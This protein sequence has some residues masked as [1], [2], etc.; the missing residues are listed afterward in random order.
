MADG[1]YH[2]YMSVKQV[3]EYLQLNEK[4]VYELVKDEQ[5]PAT[6]VTGKWLFPRGLIDRWL[7]DSAH[8]GLLADRLNIAGSDDPLLYRLVLAHMNDIDSHALVNYT[9][10]GTRMGL[11]LLQ[12]RRID[13]CCLH[14]GPSEESALRHPALLEQH[15]QHQQWVLLHLFKREQGMIVRPDVLKQVDA[16]QDL[17]AY[18]WRWVKRQ[19]GAGSQRFL[20]EILGQQGKN[21]D[22]LNLTEQAH[23]EREAAT[24]VAMGLADVSPGPRA[25]A[26]EAGLAFVS[27]GWEAFDMALPKNIWFRHLL[28][29]LLKRLQSVQAQEMAEAYGGYDLSETG[30]LVWGED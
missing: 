14:W 6:K 10:T 17:F 3:A 7:M 9:P 2:A 28:Q 24:L 1:D 26:T 23:S 12:A 25:A 22:D 20:M 19:A 5:I 27:F 4:K 11:R 29:K 21:V 15:R 30:K 18:R 16:E 13:A 8:G